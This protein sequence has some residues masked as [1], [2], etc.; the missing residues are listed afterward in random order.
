MQAAIHA[1]LPFNLS[2]PHCENWIATKGLGRFGE[3]VRRNATVPRAFH[4]TEEKMEESND[5]SDDRL[6]HSCRHD[7]NHGCTRDQRAIA[8]G[9]QTLK[10]AAHAK[11][12]ELAEGSPHWAVGKHVQRPASFIGELTRPRQRRRD[13]LMFVDQMY[14]VR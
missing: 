1:A 4:H 2:H 7:R 3:Q 9:T 12:G 14:R 13:R 6:R 8:A 5:R 10:R 11:F